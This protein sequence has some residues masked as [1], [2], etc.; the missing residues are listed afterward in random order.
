MLALA[1]AL[2]PS[3]AAAW[4]AQLPWTEK[5]WCESVVD[6]VWPFA[7]AKGPVSTFP[8]EHKGRTSSSFQDM[9]HTCEQHGARTKCHICED[10]ACGSPPTQT[11]S[12]QIQGVDL[13]SLPPNVPVITDTPF[14]VGGAVSHRNDFASA[15]RVCVLLAGGDCLTDAQTDYAAC[16]VRCWGE[17]APG[18][19]KPGPHGWNYDP[20]VGMPQGRLYSVAGGGPGASYGLGSASG[21]TPAA[22]DGVPG[23]RDGPASQ[24]RFR[25]PSAVAVA[26]DGAVFVADTGNHAVRR[27]DPITAE[28]TTVAGLRDAQGRPLAGYA[29]GP[30]QLASFS[31]PS[32][33]TVWHDCAGAACSVVVV[34]AD[35][36]NHVIR[37]I[38]GADTAS[39]AAG[40]VDLSAVVVRTVAGGGSHL[41]PNSEKQG[42][43]DG[44][45]TE[46]RFDTPHGVVADSA[47]HIFVADTLNFV[48]RHI[49]P[50]GEVRTLAGQVVRSPLEGPGCPA[51][52]VTGVQGYRDGSRENARF[53][54]PYDVALGEDATVLVADGDRLRRITRAGSFS[55]PSVSSIQGIDSYDRVVTL[56]GGLDD[57]E[58]DGISQR[59]R[60][61]KPRGVAMTADGRMYLADSSSCRIRRVTPAD[62]VARP[63]SCA[64][65][66]V[67]VWRPRGCESY[68]PDVDSTGEMASPLSGN[69]HYNRDNEDINGRSLPAN[70]LGASPPDVGLTS[71]RVTS[72]PYS[73]T[74]SMALD[75]QEDTSDLSTVRISCPAACSSAAGVVEGD[76]LYSETSSLCLAAAHAGAMDLAAGGL[77][78]VTLHRGWGAE[79]A[80]RGAPGF[81]QGALPG[82][83]SGGVTSLDLVGASRT[84]AVA[85]YNLSLVEVETV[86]GAANAPLD[87]A[88]G[89]S[90][91]QPPA[92]ARLGGP[93]GVA[94]R[95]AAL[96]LNGTGESLVIADA[97]AHAIRALTASCARPCENGGVCAGA[98]LCECSPG[99]AGVDCTTPVCSSSCGSRQICTG[100]DT[101]TCKPGYTG[102][103][104][105]DTP[106]CVQTCVNGACTAPDTCGCDIG[107]FDANCTTP[108]C[109]MTCGNGGNCTAPDTCTC[110]KEWTGIDCR[111][112]VCDQTCLNGATCVAPNTCMCEPGWSGHDCSKPICNQGFFEA[113][114]IPEHSAPSPW[115]EPG[116][117]RY[118]PC[119]LE[120]WCASTHEFDCLQLEKEF[121][122]IP[123]P[124]VR[125]LTGRASVPP[126]CMLLEL[127]VS[128]VTFFR[129]ETEYDNVTG[130][131]RRAPLRPYGWGPSNTSHVWSS[132]SASASDRQLA[133]AQFQRETQG[134]YVCANGGNC[135]APGVCKCAPGWAGFDCRTPVCDIGY[136]FRDRV[137]L[138]P[139]TTGQ[140][141]YSCSERAVTVWENP[142]TAWKFRGYV[143]EHPNYYSRF[144]DDAIGWV[145]VHEH[146][147]PLGDATM[148]GWRRDGWWERV[149]GTEWLPE[150]NCVTRFNRTCP[151]DVNKTRDLDSG[152]LTTPTTNTT[153]SFLPRVV[154]TDKRVISDGRWVAPGGEC[155]DQVLLG[156]FNGGTC[157]GPNTCQCAPGW[158]GHDC[159]LPIC[160]QT[161]A[162][163]TNVSDVYL[164]ETIVRADGVNRGGAEPL[165]PAPLLGTDREV[166]FRQCPNHG[167]CT[168]PDTCTCE[169]GWSGYNCTIPLCA[170][171]CFNGGVCTAPDTCTCVQHQNTFRDLRGEPY[172]R[173][174]DGDPQLT[175]WTGYDCNTPICV[176]AERWVRNDEEGNERFVATTNDGVTFQG[177]CS[178]PTRFTPPSRV[179]VSADL[180]GREEWYQGSWDNPWDNDRATSFKAEGRKQRVNH[181]NFVQVDA[182]TW[183]EGDK[184]TGEGIYACFNGG[185]CV[186]PDTCECEAGRWEGFDCNVPIC[187][188]TDLFGLQRGCKHGVCAA[189]DECDCPQEP[190]LLPIVHPDMELAQ[191]NTGW[192][193][194]DC[195]IPVC[196]Q[197]F[198]D[199]D[200]RDVA[201]GGSEG[202]AALGQGCW[203]CANGGNC[204]A[205][206]VCECPP[207]WTGF[208]CRTP[209]CT[210]HATREIIAE[211]D[212]VDP[213]KISAFELDPCG[214]NRLQ[215]FNG[216]QTGRGN[217]SAPDTCT[218]L[219]KQ[220]TWLDADGNLVEEPWTDLFNRPIP[221]GYIFGD[222]DCLDG[223]QGS[224]NP[225][226]SFRTCHLTIYVPTWFERNT[227]L[228]IIVTASTVFVLALVYLFVRRRLHQRFLAMR[229]EKR[230]SRR[231][232]DS[233]GSSVTKT[234]FAA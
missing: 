216:V 232:T 21:T 52:C 231:S 166:Q 234:A 200:C 109:S 5:H 82:S 18:R 168:L 3:P 176:Q 214:T 56:A 201:P 179:R 183:V 4:R 155:V 217:C 139:L 185:S 142:R 173:R 194:D 163:L 86:A 227:L 128:A 35:T 91:T 54:H 46:A 32:G 124:P 81:G 40:G 92:A 1:L 107:W 65:R 58:Q 195:S 137:S 141:T 29:D 36:Y 13:A 122:D 64:A 41:P 42:L 90:D 165:N 132:P 16:P 190:S 233:A 218:C 110:P 135:T 83:P 73:G 25:F 159:T 51:P 148:E 170:Q 47:G 100:P 223:F 212:T 22:G 151:A 145:S 143:H 187:S 12:Y 38:R 138:H 102:F 84:F 146:K 126:R 76:G 88:C 99:W 59:A 178:P 189:P 69:V 188:Y 39:A 53:W 87:N 162:E 61:D 226:G 31:S 95:P 55:A 207:E 158:E 108:M 97:S 14:A 144:M 118:T 169:K 75:V 114:P 197:G 192:M 215:T 182:S 10:I 149:P 211:L 104:A 133:L 219:C 67:D 93:T 228:I 89:Y 205:P 6:P 15:E 26:N 117:E 119:E 60:L 172:F 57:G 198:F 24:A 153:F 123:V 48:I 224:L 17:G 164:P 68:D 206:D 103:P 7:Y 66:L 174:S 9:R 111:T 203:R 71:A 161:V 150:I 113:D 8:E 129:Y 11:C 37:E 121:V 208:D 204:T 34:V 222:S 209:V 72:G 77:V 136:F 44:P 181:P 105:C 80:G 106:M 2:S 202:V 191:E 230:R 175:G 213:A 167:N 27:I 180:C 45:A 98:E 125:S 49:S 157:V 184:I 23:L 199:P 43:R 186:A 50:A 160:E 101:C 229:A 140:G 96:G 134:V 62:H 30:G 127:D 210:Q 79:F 193:G 63:V 33:I 147:P 225:D 70:C 74:D 94:V 196:V 221:A 171:E 115:R 177:G 220:R 156:C 28:V 130:Y 78:T 120:E 116:W 152:A 131:W 112:P 85:R 19:P 154:F 20:L